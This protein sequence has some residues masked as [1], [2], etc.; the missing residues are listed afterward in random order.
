MV[1]IALMIMLVSPLSGRIVGRHG[2]RAPLVIAGLCF[3]VACAMLIDVSPGTAFGWLLAAYLVFGIGFGFVNA[4]I[5]NAA[6]SGMPVT[7]AGVAAA[8]ATT[9]RQFGQAFGVAIVGAVA[10]SGAGE[11]APC[12]ERALVKSG[13]QDLNLRPPGPQPGALPDCATPRGR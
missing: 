8:V 1:P 7:Q 12:Q 9:S 10:A 13:R 2:P 4:P 6:V 5:T 3:S 11:Q